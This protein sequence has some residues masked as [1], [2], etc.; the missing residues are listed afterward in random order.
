MTIEIIPLE[1]AHWERVRQIYLDGIGTGHA[2]FETS[3]PSWES[4]DANHLKAGRIVAISD[5]GEV[6]GW[7]ALNRVSPRSVYAGVAEV[8]VYVANEARQMGVGKVLLG[9][10][11]QASEQNGI[12]TLQASVFPENG[13]SLSLH[14]N[15]GF[16]E[17]GIRERIGR[18]NGV[19]R[20]TILL[21]RRSKLV[22][23]Q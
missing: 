16:R 3:A 20:D 1:P 13:A 9:T 19:W 12:W 22:G 15:C 23:K 21:E 14:K 4:W 10:L 11:V 2:T 18:L 17:V 8:S 7:A 5:S 6:L